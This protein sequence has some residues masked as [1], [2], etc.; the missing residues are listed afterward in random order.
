MHFLKSSAGSEPSPGNTTGLFSGGAVI[1][2]PT[3]LFTTASVSISKKQGDPLMSCT[4]LPK[5]S[6]TGLG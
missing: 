5:S 2:L 3:S 4:P 6:E 1:K